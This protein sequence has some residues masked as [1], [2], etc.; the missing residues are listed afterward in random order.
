MGAVRA[1]LEA[2]VGFWM[3]AA[4][5]IFTEPLFRGIDA[6]ANMFGAANHPT[7]QFIKMTMQYSLIPIGISILIHAFSSATKT[8]EESYVFRW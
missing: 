1:W 6:L 3:I 2:I 8:E 7:Y 5:I 4:A